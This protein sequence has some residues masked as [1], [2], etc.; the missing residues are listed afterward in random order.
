MSYK[1]CDAVF[2]TVSGSSVIICSLFATLKYSELHRE[3]AKATR[4]CKNEGFL[5]ACP[6]FP[7]LLK[8]MGS[9]ER[10]KKEPGAMPFFFTERN[11]FLIQHQ[12]SS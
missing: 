12:N 9:E 5:K 10:C 6:L 7:I 8:L 11:S 3:A 2:Q 4:Q 1:D